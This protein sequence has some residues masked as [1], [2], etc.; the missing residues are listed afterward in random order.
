MRRA[1]ALDAQILRWLFHCCLKITAAFLPQAL[2]LGTQSPR[3]RPTETLFSSQGAMKSIAL[4]RKDVNMVVLWHDRTETTASSH[5]HPFRGTRQASDSSYQGALWLSFRCGSDTVGFAH[6]STARAVSTPISPQKVGPF[7]PRL[8]AGA[9][10]A[11]F[12]NMLQLI[13]PNA[14]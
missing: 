2:R 4:Y 14:D 3:L 8:K 13:L 5:D 12:C 6:D 7:L 10:W 9:F 1:C 11:G